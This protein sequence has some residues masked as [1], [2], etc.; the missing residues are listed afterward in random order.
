MLAFEFVCSACATHAQS[1]IATAGVVSTFSHPTH[2][3][4]FPQLLAIAGVLCHSVHG[5]T[6]RKH[7]CR[8]EQAVDNLQ[9]SKATTTRHNQ[10]TGLACR[11]CLAHDT[12]QA[13]ND[14]TTNNKT[15]KHTCQ[16]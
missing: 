5:P 4:E 3:R 6:H 14:T 8:S 1:C 7:I 16:P 10:G 2:H 15:A 9:G 12:L 13:C 11:G